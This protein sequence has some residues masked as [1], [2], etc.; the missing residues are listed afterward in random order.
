MVEAIGY[1]I[2]GR[3][4]PYKSDAEIVAVA[5]WF[6]KEYKCSTKTLNDMAFFTE[7]VQHG[8]LPITVDLA[9][10]SLE[11]PSLVRASCDTR[12]LTI[13]LLQSVYMD[14]T[15]GRWDAIHILFHE[16]G[17][18]FLLHDPTLHFEPDYPPHKNEDSEYQA[19][20]FANTVM[21]I[22]TRNRWTEKGSQM[23]LF[24]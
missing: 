24:K 4:V 13:T 21:D 22:I 18:I 10:D 9:E 17:H 7:A 23:M 15:D 6:A 11:V 12:E 3:R 1:P 8:L 20:V 2:K 5:K 16:L 14:V 19:D